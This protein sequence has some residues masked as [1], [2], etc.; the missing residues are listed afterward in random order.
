VRR[1][2]TELVPVSNWGYWFELD[3]KRVPGEW[4]VTVYPDGLDGPGRP[5]RVQIRTTYSG[6]HE[7][8]SSDSIFLA[9][10]PTPDSVVFLAWSRLDPGPHRPLFAWEDWR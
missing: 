8:T 6:G 3:G 7:A 5:G 2:S 4:A 10:S 9:W 1:L